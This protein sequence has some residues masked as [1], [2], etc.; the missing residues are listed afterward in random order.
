[1]QDQALQFYMHDGPTAFRLELAGNLNGEG[2]H[3][4][5]QDWRTSSS[6]IGDRRLIVDMTFVT[7]V[8]EAGR[9]LISR[10]NRDGAQLIANSEA[11]RGLAES[12]LNGSLPERAAIASK[13]TWF[14]FRTSFLGLA[15][16][17]LLLATL[18]EN[19][20]R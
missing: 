14:P 17:L 12:I 16:I 9:T 3:R 11:S 19:G 10:W 5:A 20:E 13:P 8:D 1:M 7:G 4:L 2:V 15:L 18:F 6:V